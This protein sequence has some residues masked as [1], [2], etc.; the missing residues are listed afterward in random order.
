MEGL[1]H[2]GAYFWNF[3]VLY[4]WSPKLHNQGLE[5]GFIQKITTIFEGFFKDHLHVPG[6][7]IISQIAQKYTLAIHS[8]R[9]LRFELFA[10][11]TSLNFSVHLS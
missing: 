8:S 4:A 10:P 3:T 9:T 2:G 11:T 6:I 1:I 7:I 5:T